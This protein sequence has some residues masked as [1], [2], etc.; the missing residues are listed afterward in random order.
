MPSPPGLAPTTE[1][2]LG[3]TKR[4]RVTDLAAK[5]EYVAFCRER[6]M[7]PDSNRANKAWLMDRCGFTGS[8][9][10]ATIEAYLLD[11]ADADRLG[12]D[13]GRSDEAFLDWLMRQAPGG[14]KRSV[15]KRDWRVRS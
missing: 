13:T 14:R 10:K 3:V 1:P 12:N 15:C 6:G 9:A 8:Q 2:S 5:S 7:E 4:A 11:C